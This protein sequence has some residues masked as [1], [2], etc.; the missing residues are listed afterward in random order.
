MN[1]QPVFK[2]S[3]YLLSWRKPFNYLI[4]GFKGMTKKK[5]NCSGSIRKIR[6]IE[7]NMRVFFMRGGS[8]NLDTFY[9]IPTQPQVIAQIG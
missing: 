5:T 7:S 2:L 1:D 9:P 3:I 8:L 4:H 6:V